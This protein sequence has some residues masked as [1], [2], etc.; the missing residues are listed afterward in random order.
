MKRTLVAARIVSAAFAAAGSHGALHDR[1]HEL[2]DALQDAV[3]IEKRGERRD[4]DDGTGD[5]DDEDEG[6]IRAKFFVHDRRR[7]ERAENE[8]QNSNAA[9]TNWTAVGSPVNAVGSENQV[10]IAPPVGREFFR[11]KFP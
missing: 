2:N 7:G 3:V 4:D 8:L 9:G 6:V 10:I 11:L 5:G 1:G